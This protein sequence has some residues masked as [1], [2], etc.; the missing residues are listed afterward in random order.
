[1]CRTRLRGSGTAK[2]GKGAYTELTSNLNIPNYV[3]SN[4]C[5]RMGSFYDCVILALHFDR[6][7]SGEFLVI[8]NTY[9]HAA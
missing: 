8:T 9:L 5:S 3:Y 6:G 1:M 7:F 2:S 4:I